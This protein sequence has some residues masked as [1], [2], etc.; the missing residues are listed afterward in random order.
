MQ[1][2]PTKW[3]YAVSSHLDCHRHEFLVAAKYETNWRF[4]THSQNDYA[5][6]VALADRQ[7]LG[8][9]PQMWKDIR[10]KHHECGGFHAQLGLGGQINADKV[11]KDVPLLRHWMNQD[12]KTKKSTLWTAKLEEHVLNAYFFYYATHF[13]QSQLREALAQIPS[14]FCLGDPDM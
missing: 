6:G 9:V 10:H 8:E 13:D 7:S 4:V 3:T 5:P 1:E 14:V 12:V 11:W 2:E